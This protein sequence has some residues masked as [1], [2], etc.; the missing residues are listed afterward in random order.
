[1]GGICNSLCAGVSGSHHRSKSAKNIVTELLSGHW[2]TM[3][4]PHPYWAGDAMCSLW[5]SVDNCDPCRLVQCCPTSPH[6]LWMIAVATNSC[7]CC[8]CHSCS[9][10]GRSW[11]PRIRKQLDRLTAASSSSQPQQRIFL[12]TSFS[13]ATATA[14][15]TASEHCHSVWE[16]Q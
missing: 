14:S 4:T 7:C 13:A 12:S 3:P 11:E 8:C 15:E 2:L 16:R 5:G 10:V 6:V 9:A 1:V